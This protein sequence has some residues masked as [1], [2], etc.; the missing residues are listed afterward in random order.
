VKKG[1]CFSYFLDNSLPTIEAIETEL[2][3]LEGAEK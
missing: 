1:L 3:D 2:G